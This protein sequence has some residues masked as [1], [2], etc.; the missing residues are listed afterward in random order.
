MTIFSISQLEQLKKSTNVCA[1]T[2]RFESMRVQEDARPHRLRLQGPAS[3]LLRSL[4]V[5]S[6]N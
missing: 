4:K 1:E 2:V 5:V 6:S 3:E